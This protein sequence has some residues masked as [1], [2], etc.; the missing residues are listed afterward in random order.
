MNISTVLVTKLQTSLEIHK[1][2]YKYRFP[3]P[4][5]YPEPHIAFCL[6]SVTV[7]QSFLVPYDWLF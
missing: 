7:S 3:A 5:S 1:V 2:S 6:Q 4:G